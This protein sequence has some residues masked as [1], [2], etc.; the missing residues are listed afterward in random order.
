MKPKLIICIFVVVRRKHFKLMREVVPYIWLNTVIHT[1]DIWKV[2]DGL[3]FPVARWIWKFWNKKITSLKCNL[4]MNSQNHFY[5]GLKWANGE[6]RWDAILP[7]CFCKRK[8]LWI[9]VGNVVYAAKQKAGIDYRTIKKRYQGFF[10]SVK[11]FT[12]SFLLEN[13]DYASRAKA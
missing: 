11:A 7:K 1:K 2:E 13:S 12:P 8:L 3:G 9:D 6:W 4:N 10:L 5:E